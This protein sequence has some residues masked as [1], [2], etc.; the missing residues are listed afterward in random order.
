MFRC[1]MVR[2]GAVLAALPLLLAAS[3]ARATI[4]Q[5]KVTGGSITQSTT[6]CIGGAGVNAMPS[7]NLAN[8]NLTKAYLIGAD[9]TSATMSNATLVTAIAT[10]A[11][12]TNA[13]LNR[14]DLTSGTLTNA[15]LTGAN[16]SFAIM[17][18]SALTN[19]NLSGADLSFASL[20]SSTLTNATFAGAIVDG[21]N[22]GQS[23]LSK[24]QLYATASYQNG[25]LAEITLSG[26]LSA[27]NFAG[28]DLSD[29]VFGSA[30][31]TSG[32]FAN[33][34]LT[35]TVLAGA[36]L[37]GANLTGANVVD[38]NFGTTDL[39]SSQLYSTAGYQAHSLPGIKLTNNDLT[40]WDFSN[41]DLTGAALTNAILTNGTLSGANLTS[42][43][44][45]GAEL[46]NVNMTGA[47]IVGANFSGATGLTNSQL[48]TTAS[49]HA[50]NL[51]GISLAGI[52]LSGGNYAGQGLT[53]AV[54]S[55]SPLTGAN[56]SN[57]NMTGAAL[58]GA[59]LANANLRFANLQDAV[60][61]GATTSGANFSAAD[62]RGAT[63]FS[64]GG[65][66]TTNTILPDGTI[67]GLN[68]SGS[69][70]LLP[71][72][73]YTGPQ[74]PLPIHVAGGMTVAAGGTLQIVLTE[75]KW[76]STMSFD[77]GIPVSLNGTLDL[78][79]PGVDPTSLLSQ[80][81]QLFDWTGVTPSGTF[82]QVT[83]HLPSR[84]TWD[85]S[86]LYTSGTIDLTFSTTSAPITGQWATNGGGNWSSPANWSGGNI[87]GAPQ[88]TAAFGVVLTAGTANVNLDMPVN[89]AG[90]TFSPSDG[91]SYLIGSVN[92][93]GMTLSN[94]A[95]PADISSTSGTN[96]IA[97]PITMKSN[98][99]VS[100]GSGSLL[101]ISG[102]ITESGTSYG[103]NFSGDGELVLSGAN[104]F[105]GGATVS[106]GTMVV[107]SV[108][109]LEDGSNL[110]VGDPSAFSPAPIV[111]AA[112]SAVAPVPEPGTVALVFAAAVVLAAKSWSRRRCEMLAS[113]M[114]R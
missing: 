3:H 84:Y 90:L 17:S 52:D 11:T 58:D 7:A 101:T 106:G 91:A 54:F 92:S 105:S 82:S 41:Q 43:S 44:L 81:I 27:W 39:S 95:G 78:Q 71:I 65:T 112:T 1:L 108:D 100:A 4:F 97:A 87:P 10:S 46:T 72:R 26:N 40:G 12:L 13:N 113:N 31:L 69:N 42:A 6:A 66:T 85:T 80:S 56:F 49:Y 30:N 48:Y 37:S 94:T 114:L 57:A 74:S 104:D 59:I 63:D 33:A 45:A 28:Q 75:P 2:G 77:P 15:N 25:N 14:A 21:V 102:A 67:Q 103:L 23:N 109:G 35:G 68:L 34:N 86:G 99:S 53:N 38:T 20:F 19:A 50:L 98:L 61:T 18:S 93:S 64:A 73:D 29:A 111:P 96:E 79:A 24:S 5:W 9:L 107:T 76:S 88:D 47:T 36:T 89:L 70:S 62:L 83:S 32:T 55:N 16:L 51:Q 60:F 22:F 110:T 8:L